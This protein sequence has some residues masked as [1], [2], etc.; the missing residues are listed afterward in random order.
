[1]L[2]ENLTGRMVYRVG[3]NQADEDVG[4]QVDALSLKVNEWACYRSP[5]SAFPIQSIIFRIP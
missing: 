2:K 4:I 1:M 5:L 3:V